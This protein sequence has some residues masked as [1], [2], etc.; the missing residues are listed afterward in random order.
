MATADGTPLPEFSTPVC[1]TVP[2][3]PSGM[4]TSRAMLPVVAAR[5]NH[6]TRR[7]RDIYVLAAEFIRRGGR[8]LTR[9]ESPC[10]G[11]EAMGQACRAGD[12][13]L[14][15][16]AEAMVFVRNPPV[17]L[18]PNQTS[19]M[20]HAGEEQDGAPSGIVAGS[21]NR[22]IVV[23]S[24]AVDAWRRIERRITQGSWV[25][26]W[27]KPYTAMLCRSWAEFRPLP[28]AELQ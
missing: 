25:K 24:L 12:R 17:G 19:G 14:I 9:Y 8:R 21:A 4:K 10:P 23:T 26:A 5:Q 20:G 1:D 6:A 27:G 18:Q 13:V 16:A 3:V 11:V 7:I 28:E 2:P 15:N 22:R